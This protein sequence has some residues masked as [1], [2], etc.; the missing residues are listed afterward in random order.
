MYRKPYAIC[1]LM[2]L[3]AWSTY[4]QSAAPADQSSR[5]QVTFRFGRGDSMI[6]ANTVDLTQDPYMPT[7]QFDF[8]T[9]SGMRGYVS[10][11]DGRTGAIT[12][13]Q[14]FFGLRISLVR[15]AA[16]SGQIGLAVSA[17]D[18]TFEGFEKLLGR[19]CEYQRPIV[20]G[21]NLPLTHVRLSRGQ[22][23]SLTTS[24]PNVT[25]ELTYQP[26]Q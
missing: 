15:E 8:R 1:A 13:A 17:S 3:S 18:T 24:D 2:M 19:E 12:P 4:V 16:P 5:D 22:T 21:P 14:I 20:S 9:R 7:P 10:A 23:I 25:L 6:L 26:G 11:C